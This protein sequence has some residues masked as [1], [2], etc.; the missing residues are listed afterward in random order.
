MTA[1]EL[2]SRMNNDVCSM[3]QR[4]D[5]IRCAECVVN[6]EWNAVLVSNCCNAFEVL[7]GE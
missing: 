7:G 2:G 1:E 4:T 5:E 6:D 3:L